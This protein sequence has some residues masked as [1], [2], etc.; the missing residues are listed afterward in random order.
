MIVGDHTRFHV[1]FH[2]REAIG[3]AVM[4]G[5][6]SEWA[7]L[8]LAAV[9]LLGAGFAKTDSDVYTA[10]GSGVATFQNPR[11]APL[12]LPGCAPFVFERSLAGGWIDIG[13]PYL[14]VW[15]GIA[16][17]VEM[18]AIVETPFNAPGDS[19]IYRLRYSYGARCDADLPLSE[20]NCQVEGDVRSSEFEVERGLCDSTELGCRFQP[21]A[22]NFLCADGVHIGGP[23]S[24]CTRDP[25]GGK[26]GYEFLICP[27]TF[28]GA[29]VEILP[30]QPTEVDKIAIR[31]SGTWPDSCVP[32]NP[33]TS[34]SDQQIRIDTASFGEICLDA[35]TEWSELVAIGQLVAGEYE[36]IVANAM[37]PAP[38]EEMA[39]I[40]FTVPEPSG[41]LV[42]V[43]AVVAV[44]L[45][46]RRSRR[47]RDL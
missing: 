1:R 45:L 31:I 7:A 39:R 35:S 38:P 9:F 32:T 26:C 22:P 47:T 3:D 25:N 27:F 46:A 17:A 44:T 18:N 23:A 33:V 11:E 29:G 41:V 43:A 21:A 19:G 15:E 5:T 34:I 20:S 10:A 2:V 37:I 4:L 42:Q 8:A 12:Y 6:R 40:P 36:V 24:D 16:V 13:P 28:G 14:C 30:G